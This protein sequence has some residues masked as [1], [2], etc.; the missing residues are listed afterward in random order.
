MGIRLCESFY[1]EQNEL[2]QPYQFCGNSLT[3]RA[4]FRQAVRQEF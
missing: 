2:R 1:H 3:D 4:I